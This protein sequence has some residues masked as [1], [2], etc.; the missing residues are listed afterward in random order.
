MNNLNI[1]ILAKDRELQLKALLDSFFKYSKKFVPLKIT[2]LY[3]STYKD[4]SFHRGTYERY[5]KEI[6]HF[7]LIPVDYDTP[8][9]IEEYFVENEYN[10]L[11][12]DNVIFTQDFDLTCI[13]KLQEHEAL[14][15][16]KGLNRQKNSI[17]IAKSSFLTEVGKWIREGSLYSLEK[18]DLA[19][20]QLP[21]HN[22]FKY[23]GKI[24]LHKKSINFSN[25]KILFF[26]L[27]PCFI[28]EM[29]NFSPN[30][31]MYQY[32]RKFKNDLELVEL[33]KLVPKILYINLPHRTDRKKQIEEEILKLEIP[34]E[35][36][37]CVIPSDEFVKEKTQLSSGLTEHE[38]KIAKQRISCILS[39][40]KAVEYAKQNNWDYVLI[41]ED[42]CQFLDAPLQNINAA[43]NELKYTSSFDLLYLGANIV[44]PTKSLS[45][46]LAKIKA[47]WCTHA[48]ILPKHMFDI[49]LNY[50]WRYQALDSFFMSL[51]STKNCYI[52]C[53]FIATQRPSY[54]DIETKDVNYTE[55]FYYYFNSMLNK[56][57]Y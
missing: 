7:K 2:I 41:L 46:N 57:D 12:P 56:N 55:T 3:D 54:S 36:I 1:F 49:I 50:D 29:K 26:P 28:D 15:L 39:H 9:I 20:E 44:A 34:F 16:F 47:A 45:S 42:D 25:K 22:H 48:Y 23:Y 6:S 18:E 8:P 21:K 38:L 51:Q 32:P 30:S 19:F 53:P 31:I 4:N 43:L 52:V 13:K 11:L 14:D 27:S 24:F 37:E 33:K 35:R 5:K 10:L 40:M 17:D